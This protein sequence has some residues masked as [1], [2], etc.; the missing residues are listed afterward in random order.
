MTAFGQ[1]AVQAVCVR[2]DSNLILLKY[3]VL[4][5]A[6]LVHVGVNG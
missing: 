2:P 4:P 6:P 3:A 5:A 1:A